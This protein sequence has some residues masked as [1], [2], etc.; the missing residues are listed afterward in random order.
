M[1]ISRSFVVEVGF[2]CRIRVVLPNYDIPEF[3]SWLFQKRIP[4]I[5]RTPTKF[6][7]KQF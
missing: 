7:A 3:L 5:P 4:L 6:D 1:Y 2:S